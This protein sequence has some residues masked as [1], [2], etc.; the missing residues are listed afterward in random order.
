MPGHSVASVILLQRGLAATA[1][2]DL[3]SLLCSLDNSLGECSV[4]SAR[5]F[6]RQKD[7]VVGV[8]RNTLQ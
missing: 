2:G 6:Q 1:H 5:Q 4:R 7:R 3:P 8:F